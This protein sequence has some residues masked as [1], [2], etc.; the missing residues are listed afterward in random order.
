MSDTRKLYR[1]EVTV[2]TYFVADDPDTEAAWEAI[3][4]E[5]REALSLEDDVDVREVT[6][7]ATVPGDWLDC[8]PWGGNDRTIAQH[9]DGLEAP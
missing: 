2:V 7:S 4:G 1:A 8:Y 9:L 5:V 3:Q 6:D